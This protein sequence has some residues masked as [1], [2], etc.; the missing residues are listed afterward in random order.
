MKETMD[1]TS[2]VA[3][4]TEQR[5]QISVEMDGLGASIDKMEQL[6]ELLFGRLE[7]VCRNL[8]LSSAS[9]NATPEEALVPL[10]QALRISVR[11]IS[12]INEDLTSLRE[13]LEN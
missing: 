3:T 6:A 9:E 5:S 2:A 13:L 8:P 1:I 4:S 11:R 12:R 10:A 7:N